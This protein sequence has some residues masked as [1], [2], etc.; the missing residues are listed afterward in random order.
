MSVPRFAPSDFFTIGVEEELFLVDQ[1]TL[2]LA[3]VSE[4]VIPA[5]GLSAESAGHEVFAAE[6]ELRSPPCRTAGEAVESLRQA[7]AAAAAAAEGASARLLGAGIHPDA[8]LGDTPLVD[9]ERYRIVGETIRGHLL[10]TPECALHVHVGMPDAES[11][12]RACNGLRRHLPLLVALSANSPYWFG[13]DSG[14][15]SARYGHVRSYPRRGVPPH[16]EGYDDYVAWVE[17]VLAAGELEDYTLLWWDVRPHPRL[18]TV[19]VRE[20]DS[21]SS[22]ENV[23]A[24]A[25]LIQALAGHEAEGEDGGEHSSSAAIAESCFRASRDGIEARI[26]HEGEVAPVP[27]VARQVMEEVAPRARELGCEGE[28][29]GI[30]RILAGA[31]GAET[32]RRAF[33]EGGIPA[34]LADLANSTGSDP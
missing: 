33:A 13:R 24:L 31:G 5:I 7:R 17:G 26:L 29:A 6:V 34:V 10:R 9:S 16:F 22:L 1:E 19:E 4:R 12:I 32:Q 8:E 23:A 20:M 2:R 11:A 14:L 25:A 15:A 30:E 21:Q 28:L 18:G 27:E 3:P